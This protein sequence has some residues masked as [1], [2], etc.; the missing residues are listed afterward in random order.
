MFDM[1]LRVRM[2]VERVILAERQVQKIWF[3]SLN[4]SK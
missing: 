3:V 4:E 2:D 1:K